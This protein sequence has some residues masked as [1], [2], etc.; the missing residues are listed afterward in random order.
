MNDARIRNLIE[1]LENMGIRSE[2]TLDQ[3]S[4]SSDIQP[5]YASLPK[6]LRCLA[7]RTAALTRRN[8]TGLLKWG[9]MMSG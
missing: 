3:G 9:G 5:D 1:T 2:R 8:P 4:A 6:R 7:A